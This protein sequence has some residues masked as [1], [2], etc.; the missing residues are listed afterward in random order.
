MKLGIVFILVG[1]CMFAEA[2]PLKPLEPIN[3]VALQVNENEPNIACDQINARLTKYS[4]M[5]RSHNNSVTAFLTQL[6]QV[7]GEWHDLLSPYEN[8][9][10]TLETGTFDILTESGE[11]IYQATDYAINNTSLLANELDRI[12]VSLRDCSISNIEVNPNGR[13][14][15]NRNIPLH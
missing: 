1:F 6:T 13:R 9:G 4:D 3:Q 12:I 15:N 14:N 11:K 7:V 5:A 2:L 10:K 8:N